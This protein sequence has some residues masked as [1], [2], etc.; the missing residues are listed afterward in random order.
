MSKRK[1]VES[2]SDNV[3]KINSGKNRGYGISDNFYYVLGIVIS[4][5]L[6]FATSEFLSTINY[7]FVVIFAVVAVI[8]I[9][10]FI[11]NKEYIN[12]DYSGIIL[13]VMCLWLALFTF[14]YGQFL[15]LELFPALV[16]LLLF[17]MGISSLIKYFN[18]GIKL[19]LVVG[20]ISVIMGIILIFASESMMYILL[21]IVGFYMF[22][23]ILLDMIN[24][25][26]NKSSVDDRG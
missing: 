23:M 19:N 14:K 2:I 11:L 15:F 1:K 3:E 8:K 25:K 13:G 24:Y 5:V 6:I 21:K 16:S 18:V 4:L 12:R 26:S 9:I 22:V 10:N 7:L 17:L 20:V